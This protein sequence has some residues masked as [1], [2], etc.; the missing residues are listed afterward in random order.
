MSGIHAG[1]RA[2]MRERFRAGGAE[3]FGTH[4][5][6][7]MLLYHVVPV[8]DVNPLAHA[9]L[10]EFGSL[11]G[12]FS[13]DAAALSRVEGIGPRIA[14]LLIEN[15]RAAAAIASAALWESEPPVYDSYSSLGE[16]FV[17]YF[18]KNPAQ[19]TVAMLLDSTMHEISLLEL[20]PLDF[21]SAGV[22]ADA[23]V[24]RSITLGASIIV[25]AH[26]HP[27]GPAYPSHSDVVSSQVMEQSFSECG[28]LLLEHYVI[29]GREYVGFHRRFG[30][31]E[32]LGDAVRSFIESKEAV[33]GV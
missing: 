12:V 31:R 1:H 29:S 6:L 17:S 15:G 33:A 25:I 22:R 26:N 10:K 16:F 8:K 11:D 5:L 30:V 7:E 19:A 27:H 18:Q 9:L 3:S 23:A 32:S 13:A 14:Q 20:A 21:G 28:V 4:E 24:E 2:R